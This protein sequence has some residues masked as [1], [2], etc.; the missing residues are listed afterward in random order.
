MSSYQNVV[1]G[2]LRLKGKPLNVFKAKAEAADTISRKK[3]KK[4]KHHYAPH[5]QGWFILPFTS[6][7][8]SFKSLEISCGLVL[9][10]YDMIKLNVL[11][12]LNQV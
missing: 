1:G 6:S 5:S 10:F 4:H 11:C 7:F 9:K 12:R 8:N 2:R 3:R